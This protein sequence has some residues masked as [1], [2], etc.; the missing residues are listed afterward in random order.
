MNIDVF[1][2]ERR[3][4]LTQPWAIKEEV[5]PEMRGGGQRRVIRKETSMEGS[6]CRKHNMSKYAEVLGTDLG[7]MHKQFTEVSAW[8]HSHSKTCHTHPP[9]GAAV[10][11]GHAISLEFTGLESPDT[12]WA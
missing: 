4:H 7:A 6:P 9:E 5:V 10:F 11:L 8:H 12:R 3:K 1:G 2:S